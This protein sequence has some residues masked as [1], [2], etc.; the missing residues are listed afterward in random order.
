M[1]PSDDLEWIDARIKE[2]VSKLRQLHI[3]A[4]NP[5]LPSID[6]GKFGQQVAD[7]AKTL[8]L[9]VEREGHSRFPESAVPVDISMILRQMMWTYNLIRW[10]NAD[11]TRFGNV[12]YLH[13]YSFVC[14]P[15][16]R[17]M[18]D[19][20]Y[21][22][23]ALL[24][25]PSKTRAF[26]ISGYYR[27]REALRED[28]KRYLDDP[29]WTQY[30]T[31]QRESLQNGM[32]AEAYTDSDLD[33]KKNKW[34]LLAQYLDAKPDSPH[35]QLLRKITLGFWKEYSS[36]SHA[37][38]DGLVDLF[39][40]VATDS[41]PHEKRDM[42]TDDAVHRYIAMHFGRTAAILLCL[43]TEIQQFFEFNGAEIDKRLAQLWSA[44]I[45]LYEIRE[46]FDYR[47]K[48]LLKEALPTVE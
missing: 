29:Q 32:R 13:P 41:L 12:G 5:E 4:R 1:S 36:I 28:E 18:I 45:P 6:A 47:Y 44:M 14:L 24:D 48:T 46:L 9:K 34:P 42:V 26:R 20:F 8:C 11:D 43:L 3:K 2:R 7:L 15:L 19:G 27:K 22:C 23:T 38:F 35:K 25:D 21:N 16:V 30:L 39:P 10:I 37:S 17:T 33:D 40:F 31:I